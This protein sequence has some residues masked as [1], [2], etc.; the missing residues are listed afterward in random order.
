MAKK[1]DA[2]RNLKAEQEKRKQ[3]AHKTRR[4]VKNCVCRDTA[5]TFSPQ[6]VEGVWYSGRRTRLKATSTLSQ[7]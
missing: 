4:R 5:T 7:I 1:G 3:K 2:N 6:D